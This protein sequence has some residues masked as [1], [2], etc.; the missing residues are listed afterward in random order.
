MDDEI[1]YVWETPYGKQEFLCPQDFIGVIDTEDN[2]PMLVKQWTGSN[3]Y[4]D[5]INI[6][7]RSGA[8]RDLQQEYKGNRDL[9]WGVMQRSFKDVFDQNWFEVLHLVDDEPMV[10]MYNLKHYTFQ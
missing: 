2:N 9:H 3:R 1:V 8:S 6:V 10:V 5:K 7:L 4:G